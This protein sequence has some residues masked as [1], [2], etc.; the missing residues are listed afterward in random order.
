MC[1]V[2]NFQKEMAYFCGISLPRMWK[3]FTNFFGKLSRV[4]DLAITKYDNVVILGDISVDTQDSNSPGLNKVQD[5]CGVFWSDKSYR[6]RALLAKPKRARR[7][8]ILLSQTALEVSKIVERLQYNTIQYNTYVCLYRE[9][10]S[11]IKKLVLMASLLLKVLAKII[12]IKKSPLFN[13]LNT[14]NKYLTSNKYFITKDLT[15]T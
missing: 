13:H 14:K 15:S 8:L 3:P 10:S 7:Q 1:R 12:I 11:I 9:P 2:K 6:S 4:E 5:L